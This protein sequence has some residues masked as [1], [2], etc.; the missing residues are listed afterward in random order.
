[1]MQENIK[2]IDLMVE[3]VDARVPYSSK[4]PDIDE[5]A[6]N[7]SRLIILN[8]TD[9]ADAQVTKEWEEYYKEKGFFVAKVNSRKAPA[10]KR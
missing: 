4:N 6:R 10:S 3:L 8:K 7:K 1:M 5:L 2:L 9:M